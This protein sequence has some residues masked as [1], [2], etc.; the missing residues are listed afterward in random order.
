MSAALTRMSYF[1]ESSEYSGVNLLNM[2]SLN[3]K[4]ISVISSRKGNFQASRRFC[5]VYSSIKVS[6]LLTVRMPISVQRMSKHLSK[7]QPQGTHVCT[8]VQTAQGTETPKSTC[9]HRCPNGKLEARNSEHCKQPSRRQGYT[10]R[11]R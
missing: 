10:V 11:T 4:S 8:D 7:H 9:L 1:I 6:S 5:A 3:M 2:E